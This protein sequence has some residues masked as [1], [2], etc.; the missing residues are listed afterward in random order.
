MTSIGNNVL[1]GDVTELLPEYAEVEL[2]EEE[3][4]DPLVHGIGPLLDGYQHR[5]RMTHGMRMMRSQV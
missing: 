4:V 5:G 1:L 2:R 3:P